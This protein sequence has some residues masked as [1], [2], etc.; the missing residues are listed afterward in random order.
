[1]AK[2]KKFGIKSV[3]EGADFDFS[4]RRMKAIVVK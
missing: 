2:M 1:M 4:Y 3:Q